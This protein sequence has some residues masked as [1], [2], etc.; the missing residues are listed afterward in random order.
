MWA[1]LTAEDINRVTIFPPLNARAF[2]LC[3]PLLSRCFP[4]TCCWWAQ[5]V[6]GHRLCFAGGSPA[7]PKGQGENKISCSS[8]SVISL[9]SQ[10][11]TR[12]ATSSGML[13]YYLSSLP[14]T[15]P[16]APFPELNSL[17]L[18]QQLKKK[19]KNTQQQKNFFLP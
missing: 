3:L 2:N 1:S 8:G 7:Q 16:L 11:L 17:S 14:S 10:V 4:R 6:A 18:K 9:N 19:K 12:P 13:F 15:S 5:G